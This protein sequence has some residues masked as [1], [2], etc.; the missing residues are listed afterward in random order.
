MKN[1]FCMQDTSSIQFE[2]LRPHKPSWRIAYI[3]ETYPPDINGVAMTVAKTVETLRARGHELQLIRPRNASDPSGRGPDP[4]QEF[5]VRGAP[6]PLYKQLKL[7]LPAKRALVKLWS[8]RRPDLVHIATEGPLGWSALQAAR[9]LKLPVCTDFRTNFHAYSQYYGLGWLK[10]AILSYM[11]KFHNK[12][13]CTMVPTQETFV[14]LQLLGFERLQVVARGVDNTLYSPEHRSESLRAQWGALPSTL[15]L[16]SVGR[17]AAE[18][19]LDLVVASYR[20]VCANKI[21]CKLVFVGDGP[22]RN[23]LQAQCP[24]AVFAGFKT[25]NDL[26]RHYASADLFLFPSLT[27]TFGNVTL[28]AMSSG[29]PVVAY[30]HAAARDLITPEVQGAL[31]PC[32]DA[33]QFVTQTIS[34]TKNQATERERMKFHARNRAMEMGWSAVA[35]R[36]EKIYHSMTE[37]TNSSQQTQYQS[38]ILST[39]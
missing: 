9:K 22:Y 28:E 8:R 39:S 17:L 36:L 11:K 4:M 31:V 5:L 15:V 13:D 25:G 1:L 20:Q 16:L 27:E 2:S 6:I 7:G 18:K 30:E 29:L 10:G 3:T 32:G 33:S 26:A 34:M 35:D 21:D 14:Q 24:D 12:A 19:N 38:N 23:V 37:L